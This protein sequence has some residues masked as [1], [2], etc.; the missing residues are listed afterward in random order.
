MKHPIKIVKCTLVKCTY[1]NAVKGNTNIIDPK[2]QHL[3]KNKQNK[4]PRRTTNSL[5]KVG[6]TTSSSYTTLLQKTR[7]PSTTSKYQLIFN[8]KVS[9]M[10][11]QQFDSIPFSA[12]CNPLTTFHIWQNQTKCQLILYAH[13]QDMAESI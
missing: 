12:T 11:S 5:E 6:I 1:V 10:A 2:V 8:P 3:R 7:V 9:E 13:Y 4:H